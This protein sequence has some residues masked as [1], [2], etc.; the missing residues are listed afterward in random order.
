MKNILCKVLP[1]L[2]LFSLVHTLSAQEQLGLRTERY[3]G[4]NSAIA[5]P[6]NTLSYPLRWDVNLIAA[7][8]F[9]ENN[10]GFLRNTS[11][12]GIIRN[13]ENIRA[14]SDFP[15]ESTIGDE[16]LL[17]DYFDNERKKFVTSSTF[18]TG[19]S[20]MVRTQSGHAFGMFTNLRVHLSS[21]NLPWQL[22]YYHLNRIPDG[23]NVNFDKTD[24]A[25]MAWTEIGFHYGYSMSTY[26]G[27]LNF[28]VNLKVLNGYEAVGFRNNRSINYAQFV[29][30]SITLENLDVT[31]AFT[32]TNTDPD[33]SSVRRNGRGI[34]LDLG[35][36]QT[37]Y[38]TDDGYQLKLG[39]SLLDIGRIRYRDRAEEHRFNMP[40]L[41]SIVDD[42]YQDIEDTDVLIEQLST[43]L[44][45]AADASLIGNSFDVWLPSAIS[46]QA[47]YRITKQLYI[48]G[49]LIQRLPTPEY[50][51]RRGN[52]F[53]VS[54]RFEHRWF[55]ASLPMSLYNWQKFR[56]GMAFRLAFLT[57][58]SD[59]IGSILGE[60][61]W[62]G[63]DFYMAL[64]INP[65]KLGLGGR[66][67]RGGKNVKCYE[68]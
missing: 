1:V 18:V 64:R 14:V 31:V 26:N 15:D 5:N 66:S 6:A 22:G 28:G 63:T 8:Q 60:S 42:P 44:L 27:K 24:L 11:L 59:N 52:F 32:N 47:D 25:A 21:Q 40:N 37:F 12:S 3:A 65:F 48:N 19:P 62:T 57:I 13:A 34:A 16:V 49:L 7:G 55:A 33:N 39:V 23:A 51:M 9:L 17:F 30:D 41:S 46:L 36:T 45:G 38:E 10:Y 61:K 43:D 56:F 29:N 67:N 20:F 2:F 50:A 4:I 35:V 53:A 54:P 68:F 58:G